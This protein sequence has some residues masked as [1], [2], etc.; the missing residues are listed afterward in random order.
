MFLCSCGK[1]T[2]NAEGLGHQKANVLW[3]TASL[4]GNVQKRAIMVTET[5]SQGEYLFYLKDLFT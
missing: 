1:D 2:W 4:T 5:Q 3:I